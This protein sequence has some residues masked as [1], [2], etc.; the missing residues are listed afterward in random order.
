MK[1]TRRVLNFTSRTTIDMSRVQVVAS[2]DGDQGF[3]QVHKLDLSGYGIPDSCP[4]ILEAM[5]RRDGKIRIELGVTPQPE[6]TRKLKVDPIFFSSARIRLNIL[7]ASGTGR[8]VA[9]VEDV[10]IDIPE[11]S[12]LRSLLP[13]LEVENLVH[14]VWKLR[15]DSD[16]FCIEINKNFPLIGEVV[17]SPEFSALVMPDVVRQIAFSVAGENCPIPEVLKNKWERLFGSIYSD[18]QD[19]KTTE[20]D[21]WADEVA[22]ALS[23]RYSLINSYRNSWGEEE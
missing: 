22:E 7:D 19:L 2:I 21:A 1:S 20:P 5:T 17:R 23:G 13:T 18:P 11:T 8:I 6:L 14:R 4:V 3:L 10:D 16:G 12:G 15:I 9:S